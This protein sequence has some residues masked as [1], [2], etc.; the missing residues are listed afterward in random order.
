MEHGIAIAA[1]RGLAILRL[2]SVP[3]AADVSRFGDNAL[4]AVRALRGKGIRGLIID[5]SGTGATDGAAH[6]RLATSL[7]ATLADWE[8]RGLPIA[9]IAPDRRGALEATR[10]VAGSAARW[11]RVVA[12]VE[13]AE[14]YL[15]TK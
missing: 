12:S 9:V 3:A 15:A 4:D 1:E 5:L 13:D 6:A 10:V 8:G 14:R 7:A 11:G 2:T